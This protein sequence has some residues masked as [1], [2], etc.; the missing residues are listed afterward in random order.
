MAALYDQVLVVALD[1]FATPTQPYQ[2]S[3]ESSR[4]AGFFCHYIISRQP[5]AALPFFSFRSGFHSD[6]DFRRRFETIPMKAPAGKLLP[7]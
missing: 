7:P 6:Q 2:L 4:Q 3:P 5:R 1:W